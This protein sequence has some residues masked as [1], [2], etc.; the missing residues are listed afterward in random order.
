ML[1]SDTV[2]TIIKSLLQRFSASK[3]Q[4][5]DKSITENNLTANNTSKHS[6]SWILL[7]G[8]ACLGIPSFIMVFEEIH[9]HPILGA[10]IFGMGIV[11][12]AFLI[13]W[14]AEAAQLDV[15]ASFSANDE[16]C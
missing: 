2:L 14:A 5:L 12:R 6:G 10:F 1:Q 9:F 7:A 13:S 11:G 8:F 16:A 3:E 4:S 15:S